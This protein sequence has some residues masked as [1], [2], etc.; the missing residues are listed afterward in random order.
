MILAFKILLTTILFFNNADV[1]EKYLKKH[2]T[3]VKKYEYK[4]PNHT[5]DEIIPDES[6]EFRL[7]KNY[8]YIPVNIFNGKGEK[9]Q[10]IVTIKIKLFQDVLVTS[11]YIN[12]NEELSLNDFKIEE[13]EV[14]TLRAEPILDFKNINKYRA[15]I[16]ISSESIIE[17]NMIEI[18]PDI[19]SGD[20]VNAI[21]NKGIIQISF[22]ATARSEGIIGEIIK[23][24]TDDKKIFKAEILNNNTVKIIE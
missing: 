13:K 4:I 19:K 8:A 20:N 14:S 7:E 10:G 3:N 16:N 22:N 11:R 18:I 24:K 23:I 5:M 12:K 9:K 15:R 6:R 17:K 2:L 21:Y 1:I